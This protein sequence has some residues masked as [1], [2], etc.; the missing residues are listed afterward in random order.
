MSPATALPFRESETLLPPDPP[1]KAAPSSRRQ[2]WLT[3]GMLAFV[4]L[5]G[6]FHVSDLD[7]GYHMRTG[8]YVLE[9]Y[10][11]PAVNTFSYTTPNEEW[12]LHQWWPGILFYLTYQWGGVTALITLKAGIATLLMFVV[13][14]AARHVFGRESL[15]TFWL[16]T[17]GVL[18]ARVRFFERPDLISALLFALVL[19]FDL[20]FEKDRRWQFL[21]LPILMAVWANTHAGVMYG[22]VLLC[23]VAGAEGIEWLW[24]CYRGANREGAAG[25]WKGLLVRPV[26]IVLSLIAAV[27]ALQ[28]INPNGYRVMLVP[29]T[30]FT[31][32]FWQSIIVEYLP[33]TWQS[34]KL[35]YLSLIALAVL[36]VLTWRRLRL[37]H[38][39]TGGVFAY[40]ACSSQR[41]ML[42]YSVVAVPY[43]AFLV[44]HLPPVRPV[45]T[46][47]RLQPVLLPMAW[48]AIVLVVVIPHKTF[49]FGIGFYRPYYPLEIY[50][51]IREQVP[52]QNIFNDMPY[53]GGMLWWLY[54]RFRPF[55]DGR[56]DAYT[57]AFWRKE[58]IPVMNADPGW[59][60]ILRKHDAHAAWVAHNP[61]RPVKRIGQAVF[62]DPEWALVA[63]ND[64]S[65]FFLE[66]TEANRALISSNE[67]RYVWPGDPAFS[68]VTDGEALKIAAVEAERAFARSPESSFAQTALARTSMMRGDYARA[69]VLYVAL[70]EKVEGA[71]F[72]WRDYGYCLLKL[73]RMDEADAVFRRMIKKGW[74][75]G[76][77]HYM[78]HVVALRKNDGALAKR[79]LEQALTL[80]PT[81]IE[82]Q[83]A[84]T[85]LHAAAQPSQ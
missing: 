69:A 78:R 49:H 10:R 53:G 14:C 23:V 1:A 9:N 25:P 85:R 60:D 33:P 81:N 44:R 7:V 19:Y 28:A 18:I 68:K 41:S 39:L 58:Y 15:L 65:L 11:I 24:Q 45:L 64:H 48:V 2:Q 59:R 40:L 6:F 13:W 71:Q 5:C 61:G 35:F 66:R 34:A 77:A 30:Q 26:G 57:P 32:R 82:Y 72:Y 4:F 56:G 37:R 12:L 67:F 27:V 47:K 63:Y 43:A 50:S 42:V 21:G 73:D 20:R 80:E 76:Y 70:V 74:L 31:S 54:P 83:Q 46:L 36:Q 79:C 29:I 55:I 51:F 52:P 17:I 3:A 84:R 62:D 16:V 38:L 22:F 8:A 75:T